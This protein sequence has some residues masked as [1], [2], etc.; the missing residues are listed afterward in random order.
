MMIMW[1]SDFRVTERPFNS[2][3]GGVRPWLGTAFSASNTDPETEC[4]GDLLDHGAALYEL[5]G[6][7]ASGW[8][9][10][11]LI[12]SES[13]ASAGPSKT[14]IRSKLELGT[15]L[16]HRHVKRILGTLR[17]ITLR[18]KKQIGTEGALER[19]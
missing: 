13:F 10:Q 14:I 6:H 3:T 11:K 9:L 4:S 16:R 18:A 19:C 12:R 5:E 17:E 1:H 8:D 7:M 2:A 15:R